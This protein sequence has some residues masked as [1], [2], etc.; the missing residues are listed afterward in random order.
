M[1]TTP[2]APGEERW[3]ELARVVEALNGQARALADAGEGEAEKALGLEQ[4]T[5]QLHN[6]IAGMAHWQVTG[7]GPAGERSE[8]NSIVVK[9]V[10]PEGL[11]NRTSFKQWNR[12]Y[13][14]VAR[15]KDDTR[16][17]GSTSFSSGRKP[18]NR[19]H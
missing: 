13:K 15:S 9:I 16:A 11:T 1:S 19:T 3:I 7:A 6:T 5:R 10:V 8:S 2:I 17:R 18:G 12:R 14:L 4:A